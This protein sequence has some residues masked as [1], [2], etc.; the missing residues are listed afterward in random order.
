MQ[1]E[2]REHLILDQERLSDVALSRSIALDRREADLKAR[3]GHLTKN[4]SKQRARSASH[5]PNYFLH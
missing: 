1:L 2:A 3:E 5:I 4:L